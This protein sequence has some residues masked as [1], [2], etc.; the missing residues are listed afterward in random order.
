M[1]P[2]E[3][4]EDI[5]HKANCQA[6]EALRRR[7]WKDVAETLHRSQATTQRRGDAPAWRI[8]RDSRIARLA[9]AAVVVIAGILMVRQMLPETPTVSPTADRSDKTRTAKSL[10]AEVF[11][12]REMAAAGDV[13][14]LATMLSEGQF[15]SKLV[16]A[17]FLAKMVRMPTLETASMHASGQLRADRQED[18]LR[19]YS[20]GHTDWLQMANGMIV[21]HSD[22]AQRQAALVRLTHD[23]EGDEQ[24]W[25]SRQREFAP[26]RQERTDLEKE[27]ASA[28]GIPTDV[29]Q[30]KDRLE[31]YNDIL[32][33][34]DEAVYVTCA[35]GGLRVQNRF[36]QRTVDLFPAEAGVRAEWHGNVVDANS[37]T[38]L[39]GLAPV[40]TDGPAPA[41]SA[42]RSRFDPVYSLNDGEFLRWVR[43]PFIPER[44]N[45]TQELPYY[46]G[47]NNPPSPLYLSFTW[48]GTLHPG[49]LALHECGLGSVLSDLGLNRYEMEGPRELRGL[50][51]GG[52]W[53]IRADTIIAPRLRA[54]EKILADELGRHIRFLRQTVERDVIVVR[55]RYERQFL[56]GHEDTNVIYLFTGPA[57]DQ[58][59]GG[60]NGNVTRMIETVGNRFNLPVIL[61]AQGLDD[62][63]VSYHTC[64]SFSQL[65]VRKPG[66]KESVPLPG[67]EGRLDSV[68]ANLARQ[69]SLDF[70]KDMQPFDVWF[71]TEI[72]DPNVGN[73]SG[74]PAN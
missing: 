55:G 57:P 4:I 3:Q 44:R 9:V 1:Q 10:R 22:A 63:P 21:V 34:M 64:A 35:N 11:A 67:E 29:N 13:K 32:D 65:F 2:A 47:T 28:T 27:L 33:G 19:L 69:T 12:I 6:P 31:K 17:N 45:Y 72:D 7:L 26:L 50:R 59:A 39:L 25:R 53:I 43:P 54:L 20:T 23:I 48:D 58:M 51:L 61:E 37:V 40:R 18:G 56:P 46:S 24:E 16:A 68:L 14:G 66:A 36:R 8:L 5:I 71:I 49:T 60:G 15:E 30:L 62:V 52:D 74:P 41:P 38:L 70:E 42:W 73:P